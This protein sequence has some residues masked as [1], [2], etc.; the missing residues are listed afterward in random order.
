MRLTM[1]MAVGV[2]V[3]ALAT[4]AMAQS[5]PNDVSG[6]A[7]YG[8]SGPSDGYFGRSNNGGS[9][10]VPT[11]YETS[12]A[13]LRAQMAN[14]ARLDGGHLTAK[15]EAEFAQALDDTNRHFHKGPYARP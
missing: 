1:G 15:H 13:V 14:R 12:L 7:Q 3:L 6:P 10:G 5:M 9:A 2:A 4:G 11:R 8:A